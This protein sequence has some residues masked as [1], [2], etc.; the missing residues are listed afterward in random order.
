ME[1][2]R[3]EVGASLTLLSSLKTPFLLLGCLA[4]P[5]YNGLCL[6]QLIPYEACSFLKGK[7][8]WI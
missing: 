5:L 3:V 2:L 7:E 8:E 6:V 4:Q 1:F